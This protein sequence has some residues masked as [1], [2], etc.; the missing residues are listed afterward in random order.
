MYAT[1]TN[2]SFYMKLHTIA[3]HNTYTYRTLLYKNIILPSTTTSLPGQPTH[4]QEVVVE[5]SC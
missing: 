1:L 5:L 3:I 2:S 4:H